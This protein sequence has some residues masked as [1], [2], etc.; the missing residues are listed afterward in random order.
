MKGYKDI[1]KIR[2][3]ILL[4][5]VPGLLFSQPGNKEK[6][7]N[8]T[9]YNSEKIT[10]IPKINTPIKFDGIVDSLE[11]SSID[12]LPMYSYRPRA[13]LTPYMRYNS[14]SGLQSKILLLFSNLLPGSKNN[15][16]AFF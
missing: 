3:I 8:T 12:T 2:F 15:T 11:W 16:N 7:A 9:D 10:L 1:M 6:Q 14:K 4:F 5:F 13:S